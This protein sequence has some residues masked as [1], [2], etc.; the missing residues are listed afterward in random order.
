MFNPLEIT[1]KDE[2]DLCQYIHDTRSKILEK[3]ESH[4]AILFRGWDVN[5]PEKFSQ[6][7]RSL[8]KTDDYIRSDISCSAGPRIEI[9]NGVFTAN[10]APC[11]ES[12]PMHHEMAQCLDPPKYVLFYCSVPAKRG[13]STPIIKSSD[14]TREF[15]LRFP[16]CA[17]KLN[18]KKIRYV[19]EFPK[20]T[21]MSSPLGKSWKDTFN[22]N[23]VEEATNYLSKNNM[24]AEWLS[25]DRLK[26]TGPIRDIFVKYK[27]D[28][29]FFTAAE[30]VFRDHPQN[31]LDERPQKTFIYGDGSQLDMDCKNALYEIGQWAMQNS[32]K[33]KW[34]Q[35][36]VLVLYNKTMMHARE[37]FVPPRKIMVS[38][39]GSLNDI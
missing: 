27:D 38:L 29:L 10:E 18:E 19:R 11:D 37:H 31:T 20:N 4:G 17:K 21:D 9:T 13:G 2:L 32:Y 6:I 14:V 7:A 36:D 23:S 33:V 5:T 34:H 24:K 26:T 3:I 22:V 39:V 30:T 1:P 25:N 15:K 8:G 12:I 28:E 35:Y 16:C